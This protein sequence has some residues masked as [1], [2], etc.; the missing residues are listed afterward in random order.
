MINNNDELDGS[1]MELGFTQLESAIYI[2]LLRHGLSTGYSIAKGLNKPAANVYKALETLAAKGG[3][4]SA[5]GDKK[6]Y[7]AVP[8]HELITKQRKKYDDHLLT[9][10]HQFESMEAA[11]VD[12]QVYQMSNIEQVFES[13]CQLI[14]NASRYLLGDMEPTALVFFAKHLENA[15]KRGVE[16]RIKAY[17]PIMLESCNITLREHGPDIHHKSADI[18]YSLS[19]D[20]AEF[21]SAIMDKNFASVIQAFRSH[22]ALMNMTVHTQI[23]YGLILTDLK[24]FL[25]NDD[26]T[27]AKNLLA[28]TEHLHPLS[29]E[30]LV[31]EHYKSRYNI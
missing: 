24:K 22:S 5:S 19:A 21:V 2:Y 7:N 4:L 31:Y 9:L 20:G 23:L 11:E 25:G 28:S 8:W 18:A 6:T 27:S 30:N 13:T 12:E 3:L 29:A 15:A 26:L 1:L 16:V 10:Q 17:E 14:E